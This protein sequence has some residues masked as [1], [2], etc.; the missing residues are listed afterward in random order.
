[1]ANHGLLTVGKDLA[2]A[3]KVARLVE[4]TAEIVWG[5][6]AL[7]A[8]VPL[9]DETLKRFAPIYPMLRGRK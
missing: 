5:A 4:R 3:L 6:Q 8:V 7:G 1:M 2:G 9:P